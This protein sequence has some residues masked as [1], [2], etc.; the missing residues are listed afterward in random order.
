MRRQ[1]DPNLYY[2]QSK[3]AEIL[4]M[5]V[6]TLEKWRSQG[7]GPPYLKDG[8]VKYPI[9]GYFQ[10]EAEQTRDG[11]KKPLAAYRLVLGRKPARRRRH[12]SLS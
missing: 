4:G 9:K 5:S 7:K 11:N 10:W 12:G 6:G 3:M 2:T 1:P 8:G